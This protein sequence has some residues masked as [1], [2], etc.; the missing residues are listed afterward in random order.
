MKSRS[1]GVV[2][3]LAVAGPLAHAQEGPKVHGQGWSFFSS[4]TVGANGMVLGAEAGFPG[5]TLTAIR[6]LQDRFDSGGRLSVVYAYQNMVRFIYPGLKAEIFGR[7]H[8]VDTDRF[9][10]A[11]T[12]GVGFLAT[13]NTPFDTVVGIDM[14][15]GLV[16]GIPV[17]SAIIASIGVD[18][19]LF[20]TFG[21]SGGLTVPI[22]A[23]VGLEYFIDKSLMVT[24]NTRMG[25]ALNVTG[26]RY[27]GTEFAFQAQ[28]GIALKL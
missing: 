4:Q 23:G 20:V 3:C 9:G 5:L 21:T 14:P 1:L 10:L 11:F 25:P 17:S 6:G 12:A 15:L 16:L 2:L 19:P 7:L 28:V 24:F 26:L 22:L 13:F 18:M 8:L 27:G